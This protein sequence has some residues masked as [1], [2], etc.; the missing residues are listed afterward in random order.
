LIAGRVHRRGDWIDPIDFA[1]SHQDSLVIKPAHEGRG[2]E[3]HIGRETSEADWR[4]LT[5]PNPALPMVIQEFI[6]P[7]VLPVHCLREGSIRRERMHLTLAL[8]V[9]DGKYEGILSRISP[10]M[11]TNVGR[12]GFVQ[13][14]FIEK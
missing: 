11:V 9:L 10:S 2:F 4:R 8:A 6:E 14:V 3:V 1:R 13:A 12:Q 7:M 5:T